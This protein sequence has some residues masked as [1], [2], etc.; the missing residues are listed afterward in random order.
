MTQQQKVVFCLCIILGGVGYTGY[1]FGRVAEDYLLAT[2]SIMVETRSPAKNGSADFLVETG[3]LA[4]KSTYFFVHDA[5]EAAGKP[6]CVGGPYVSDG[7]VKMQEAVWSKDGSVVAVRVHIGGSGGHRFSI[8][9]GTFWMDAYDFRTHHAVVEGSKLDAR[10][11]AIARLMKQRSGVSSQKLSTPLGVGK[12]LTAS[13]RREY[14][15]LDEDYQTLY[16]G[17]EGIKK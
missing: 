12:S 5:A 6:L 15:T 17:P 10:S 1:K 13:E 14:D 3:G 16:N 9:D 2:S 11:K 4:G 8:Y 7:P